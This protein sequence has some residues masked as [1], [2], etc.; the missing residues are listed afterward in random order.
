[1]KAPF[2]FGKLG[3]FGQ[4]YHG[5]WKG[6]FITLPNGA[7]KACPA[8][9][10]GGVVLIRQPGQAEVVRSP[11]EQAADA[12]AG[13]EWRNYALISGGITAELGRFIQTSRAPM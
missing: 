12:A 7:T 6:G 4:P 13:W 11:A 3:I 10:N 9:A 2:G 5:L 1:M 8:P